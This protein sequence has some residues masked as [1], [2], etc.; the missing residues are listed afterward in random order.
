M[1]NM[2]LMPSSA[3]WQTLKIFSDSGS[4]NAENAQRNCYSLKDLASVKSGHWRGEKQLKYRF[5]RV[6][7]F[8]VTVVSVITPEEGKRVHLGEYGSAVVNGG[9]DPF[10]NLS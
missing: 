5:N 7:G 8:V 9:E 4:L 2:I 10:A 3:L 6:Q 1:S